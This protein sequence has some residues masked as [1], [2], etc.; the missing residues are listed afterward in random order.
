[1]AAVS[2]KVTIGCPVLNI[3]FQFLKSASKSAAFKLRSVKS[4]VKRHFGIF[5]HSLSDQAGS[6]QAQQPLYRH[7]QVWTASATW[8]GIRNG[9][10]G[11]CQRHGNVDIAIIL[12]VNLINQPKIKNIDRIS[13]S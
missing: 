10:A 11:R 5:A 13:G 8:P 2:V 1:M 6:R 12:P 9:T 7:R 4:Q 3:V